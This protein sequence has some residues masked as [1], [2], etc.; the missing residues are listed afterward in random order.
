MR[1]GLPGSDPGS[2]ETNMSKEVIYKCDGCGITQR[3]VGAKDGWWQ[4]EHAPS[5][6]GDGLVA[7]AL[8]IRVFT[9][10]S[11]SSVIACGGRC[12]INLISQFLNGCHDSR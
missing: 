12:A 9:S 7:E 3:S 5:F 4:L 8:T 10:D 1:L 6:Q 11:T 2:V